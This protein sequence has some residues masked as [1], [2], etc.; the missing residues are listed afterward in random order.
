MATKKKMGQ[1]GTPEDGR[2]VAK[3]RVVLVAGKRC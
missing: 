1:P 2:W 3:S